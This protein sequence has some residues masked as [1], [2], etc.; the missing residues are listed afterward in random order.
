MTQN[1]I[2][3][4]EILNKLARYFIRGYSISN[5]LI[6]CG[7]TRNILSENG[8]NRRNIQ[9]NRCTGERVPNYFAVSKL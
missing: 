6:F 8:W 3:S 4:I 2:F 5:I 9:G 1:S 7:M